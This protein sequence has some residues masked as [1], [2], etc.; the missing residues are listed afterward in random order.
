MMIARSAKAPKKDNICKTI[1]AIATAT[2]SRAPG[3]QVSKFSNNH[4]FLRSKA[5]GRA[6]APATAT[7][8][9]TAKAT[10]PS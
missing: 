3:R 2:A 10:L 6:T 9:A 5:T 8:T 4:S 7:T 1:S